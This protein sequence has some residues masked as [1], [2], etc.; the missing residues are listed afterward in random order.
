MMIPPYI[1]TPAE[2]IFGPPNHIPKHTFSGG[3]FAQSTPQHV[4]LLPFKTNIWYQETPEN[5]Q[6]KTFNKNKVLEVP[7][8]FHTSHD[9]FSG[10]RNQLK[11]RGCYT[12]IRSI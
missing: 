7:R 3:I 5:R 10:V 12:V 8:H 1:Q 2:K 6:E 11:P 4:G 9:H